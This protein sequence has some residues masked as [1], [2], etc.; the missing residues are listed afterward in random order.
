MGVRNN[1]GCQL[2]QEQPA[3]THLVLQTCGQL[4]DIGGRDVAARAVLK[5]RGSI[6]AYGVAS[7]L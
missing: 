5:K 7:D 3:V 2:G 4:I 6:A 1:S